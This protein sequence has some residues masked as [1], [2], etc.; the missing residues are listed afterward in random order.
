VKKIPGKAMSRNGFHFNN[1]SK[2]A[3]LAIAPQDNDKIVATYY[4][5]LNDSGELFRGDQY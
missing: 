4:I 2:S 3:T 5:L 1:Q